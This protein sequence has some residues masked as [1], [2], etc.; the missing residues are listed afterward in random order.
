MVP[1]Y[2]QSAFK[3]QLDTK[4]KNYGPHMLTLL[5]SLVIEMFIVTHL[6]PTP[7]HLSNTSILWYIKKM[8]Q[9]PLYEQIFLTTSFY[10]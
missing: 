9:N 8:N 4:V 10:M 2:E 3:R 7:W 5:T 1:A 6:T